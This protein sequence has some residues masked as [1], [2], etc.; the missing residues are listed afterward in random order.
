MDVTLFGI[1]MLVRL[2]LLKAQ[3]PMEE[4]LFGMLTAPV[5]VLPSIK[6]PF[7]TTNGFSSCFAL[8]QGVFANA[9]PPINVTLSGIV[10]LARL[11]QSSKA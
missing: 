5:A 10:T 6:I 4:T 2:E 7:T 11:V 8:N 3:F 9:S 1:V